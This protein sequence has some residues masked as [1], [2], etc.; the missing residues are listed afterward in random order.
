M[1]QEIILFIQSFLVSYG[2]WAFFLLGFMEEVLF[3]IPSG[4]LFLAIGFFAIG[5][6]MP[7]GSALALAFGPIAFAG[8]AGVLLG[9]SLM[10]GLAYWGGK[11]LILKF[12][13][14]CG[15]K[16]QDVEK[17]QRF[18]GRGYTY[19]A[20]LIA[21]RAIPIFAISVVSLLCGA[22]RIRPFVF[23]VITFVGT[24]F[25]VGTLALFGWYV[26]REFRSE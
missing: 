8:S 14:Y 3:L 5:G 19:E 17:M 25:R 12:G 7:F 1:I 10:Y 13:A 23:I 16:W 9:A 20:V 22:V 4:L 6:A 21:L 24:I 11:P 15:V 2:T 26:G 18:F